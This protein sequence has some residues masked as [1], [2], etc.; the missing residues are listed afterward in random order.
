MIGEPE[1]RP[2]KR[3]GEAAVER[4]LVSAAAV[5]HALALQRAIHEATGSRV[6]TGEILLLRRE[7]REEDFESLLGSGLLPGAHR[8]GLVAELFGEIA[9]KNGLVTP[10]QFLECLEIQVEERRA[11]R[12]HRL[13]GSIL[14]SKGYVREKELKSWEVELKRGARLQQDQAKRA[15]AE[16]G[17]RPG[18]TPIDAQYV[19]AARAGKLSAKDVL[20]AL[21][22][23]EKLVPIL[24]RRVALWEDLLCRE[25][26]GIRDHLQL[27][28]DT[29]DVEDASLGSWLLGGIFVE[30]GYAVPAQVEE[31]LAVR[32]REAKEGGKPRLLGELLI[33]RGVLTK[34]EVEEALRIQALRRDAG[35]AVLRQVR[36][37][38]WR[39]PLVAV[40]VAVLVV[41]GLA[42]W[43]AV[44][45]RRAAAT[46][47]DDG[48]SLVA[49]LAALETL[50]ADGGERATRAIASLVADPVALEE[51]RLPSLR[52]LAA[53]DGPLA[54]EAVRAALTDDAAPLRAIATWATL[55]KEALRPR[56]ADPAAAVRLAAARGLGRAGELLVRKELV[57]ALRPAA[58]EVR[59]LAAALGRDEGE[60]RTAIGDA[61]HEI[62]G[63][64]FGDD[65]ARW[66]AW[67]ALEPIADALLGRTRDHAL[68]VRY[69]VTFAQD[70]LSGRFFAAR[71]LAH[72]G[73][74]Q[75]L[76]LLVQGL[77]PADEELRGALKSDRGID[78]DGLRSEL[79]SL[80]TLITGEKHGADHAAWKSWLQAQGRPHP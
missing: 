4:G 78:V 27:V 19:K 54:A 77:D 22:R 76:A 1:V 7:I 47:A 24:G 18:M 68:R 45:V 9:L 36:R 57:S 3:T 69:E 80:L 75:G 31:A 51:L 6:R 33:A 60:V 11:R 73:D 38:S 72:M 2:R 15:A 34:A 20:D 65:H 5:R 52:A 48:A 64:T 74:G 44:R 43:P 39:G 46:L 56:L 55:A 23:L 40:A 28:H 41:V 50:A 79:A 61:L 53:V 32:E 58:P 21:T 8:G 67:L 17:G 42:S 66:E 49:R 59:D 26:I 35:E 29:C 25:V 37:R 62:S 16:V 13:I 71:A 63:F 30:L 10:E 70:G 12:P 14:V